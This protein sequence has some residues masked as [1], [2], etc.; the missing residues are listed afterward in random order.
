[1]SG[2]SLGSASLS[3]PAAVQTRRQRRPGLQ[4][5]VGSCE[6]ELGAASPVISPLQRLPAVAPPS[7]ATKTSVL[8]GPE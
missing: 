4:C 3:L 7:P 8:P 5:P 2:P 1:M 6:L